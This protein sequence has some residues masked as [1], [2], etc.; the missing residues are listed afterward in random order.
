[1]FILVFSSYLYFYIFNFVDTDASGQF[2][3][4]WYDREIEQ[5][6]CRIIRSDTSSRS[7]RT[8][9]EDHNSD[10]SDNNSES[11]VGG[12]SW[13]DRGWVG[14]KLFL[15]HT[16]A[17]LK[18]MGQCSFLRRATL[19]DAMEVFHALEEAGF[20]A[21]VFVTPSLEADKGEEDRP[22][23]LC[24]ENHPMVAVDNGYHASCAACFGQS[25]PN[26]LMMR[27]ASC[28]HDLCS[29]CVTERTQLP[30][31][32]IAGRFCGDTLLHP[33]T[34][35]LPIT[36][37]SNSEQGGRRTGVDALTFLSQQVVG[38][39]T[40]VGRSVGGD[41]ES[42]MMSRLDGV[43]GRMGVE[44]NGKPKAKASAVAALPREIMG[45]GEHTESL[46]DES[47]IICMNEFVT[48]DVMMKMPCGHWFHEGVVDDGK[49]EVKTESGVDDNDEG[50]CD[51]ILPWLQ[52]SNR[53]KHYFKLFCTL[54]ITAFYIHSPTIIL[55]IV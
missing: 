3:D 43:F 51:G 38:D 47:C 27:C 17:S 54:M 12:I 19:H 15:E 14:R 33:R 26:D 44:K 37:P 22:V 32:V 5:S 6:L 39:N 45:K 28:E 50:P 1:M 13:E 42:A 52:T 25:R 31:P 48:G 35:A 49:E 21:S 2:I 55:N 10:N 11:S 41:E 24:P 29:A 40:G 16:K 36:L 7:G 53:C 46:K 30:C 34:S 23:V 20:F 18:K 4:Q 9:D 8:E